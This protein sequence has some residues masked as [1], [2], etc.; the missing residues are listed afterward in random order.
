MID[1]FLSG[2]FHRNRDWCL[3]ILWPAIA[4]LCLGLVIGSEFARR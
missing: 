3:N 1:W 2:R 4:A